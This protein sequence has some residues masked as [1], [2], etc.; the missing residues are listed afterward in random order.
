MN[1]WKLRTD[2]RQADAGLVTESLNDAITFAG[3]SIASLT[4]SRTIVMTAVAR[5][6]CERGTEADFDR[7][8]KS[9]ALTERLTREGDFDARRI[10]LLDFYRLMGQATRNEVLLILVSALPVLNLPRDLGRSSNSS[11]QFSNECCSSGDTA[12]NRVIQVVQSA[13]S[14]RWSNR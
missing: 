2:I 8:E 4:E 3:V 10:Q 12:K 11:V 1:F 6:A 7:M 13:F 5:L 9:I 14:I